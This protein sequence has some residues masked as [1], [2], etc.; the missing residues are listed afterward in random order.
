VA[1]VDPVTPPVVVVGAGIA[2]VAC[3][4]AL[5]DA[6]VPVRVVDRGRRIGGRMA[7]RTVDG[8]PVDI[9]AS[10]FTARDDR[11]V[12]VVDDWVAR[13]LA[14][15]WTD[16]FHIADLEGIE[17]TTVGPIRYRAPGG[18]RSLVEELAAGLDVRHPYDVAEVG[19]NG[20]GLTVDG[21]RAS[22]V[23]LAVPGP[24]AVDLLADDPAAD[25]AAA[26]PA[27]DLADV[28]AAASGDWTPTLALYAGWDQRSW[29]DIDGVFVSDSPLLTWIADDGRRR[30]DDAAV[31]VAHSSALF[32]AAHLDDPAA[33]TGP[34]LDEVRAVL[35]FA[36]EPRWTAVQR[37][38]LARPRQARPE[39][40]FLG[41]A[42]VGLCG[43]GWGGRPRVEG[44]YLSGRALGEELVSRLS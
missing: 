38:S 5:A 44:A 17:G 24:Q 25:P 41:D 26:D 36:E 14:A 29:K 15:P 11:F 39:P 9:G 40:Y 43:D 8:R 6:G 31:L 12:A 22:A 21:R 23:V 27:A 19:R 34:M 2:G 3:A 1:V 16:T 28:R 35:G 18:L 10:Y 32:A 42:L 30:G 20:D 13:R 33:A 4:R 7:V 37:W